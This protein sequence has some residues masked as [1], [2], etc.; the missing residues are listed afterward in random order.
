MQTFPLPSFTELFYLDAKRLL[1]EFG[2]SVGA[3]SCY[4]ASRCT[5]SISSS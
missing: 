1:P 3:V 2:G 4:L 5:S